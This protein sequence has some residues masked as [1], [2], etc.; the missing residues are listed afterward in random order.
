MD[1]IVIKRLIIQISIVILILAFSFV[2][3]NKV[4]GTNTIKY[5]VASD[6]RSNI[7]E[8]IIITSVI[9]GKPN[10]TVTTNNGYLLL[11]K[12]GFI[13]PYKTNGTS[14][15]LFY[16]NPLNNERGIYIIDTDT[17]KITDISKEIQFPI[18][19]Y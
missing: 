9:D 10:Q 16:G 15:I 5:E 4:F 2:V 7:K 12:E 3:V 13:N 8:L 11:E 17:Y 18:D 19:I 14:T 6:P 1:K